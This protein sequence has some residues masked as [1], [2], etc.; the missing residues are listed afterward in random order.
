MNLYFLMAALFM[1]MALVGAV[2]ASL[3]SFTILPWGL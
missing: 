2:D 1:A 3:T